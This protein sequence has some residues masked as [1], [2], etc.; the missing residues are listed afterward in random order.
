MGHHNHA[1]PVLRG[2]VPLGPGEAAPPEPLP[3]PPAGFRWETRGE[4]VERLKRALGAPEARP[5]GAV[6]PEKRAPRGCRWCGRADP[7]LRRGL[8]RVCEKKRLEDA[9]RALAAEISERPKPPPV[10]VFG[11]PPPPPDLFDEPKK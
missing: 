6:A 5:G 10:D 8:C 1:P 11:E 4:H 9:G 3:A 2:H 7:I